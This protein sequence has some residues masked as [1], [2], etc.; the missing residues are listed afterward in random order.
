MTVAHKKS[1]P[2]EGRALKGLAHCSPLVS[3]EGVYKTTSGYNFS[4]AIYASLPSTVTLFYNFIFI[5]V[6]SNAP[7]LIGNS[8]KAHRSVSCTFLVRF[9]CLFLVLTDIPIYL[10]RKTFCN[11]LLSRNFSVLAYKLLCP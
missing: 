5:L 2:G 4:I 10:F 1:P 9:A 6:S 8:T 3:G 11:P 7:F